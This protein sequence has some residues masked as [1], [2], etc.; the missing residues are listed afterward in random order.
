V[1]RARNPPVHLIVHSTGLKLC[2]AGEW[3]FEKHGTRTAE[4]ATVAMD[5]LIYGCTGQ[6]E[7]FDVQ[8]S[9]AFPFRDVLRND[10]VESIRLLGRTF[11][12][13]K[14]SHC[15]KGAEGNVYRSVTTGWKDLATGML[16]YV[17][18]PHIAGQTHSA[19]PKQPLAPTV[20]WNVG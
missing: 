19:C 17:T 2:G 10:G 5:R 9:P 15:R 7:A 11:K 16:V 8:L 18:Y 20:T 6:I 12:A 13:L 1:A 14:I 3:L 4:Q